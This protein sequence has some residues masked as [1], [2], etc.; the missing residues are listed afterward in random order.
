MRAA[1]PASEGQGLRG[2]ESGHEPGGGRG[3]TAETRYVDVVTHPGTQ[4]LRVLDRRNEWGSILAVAC[5]L[6]DHR[7]PRRKEALGSTRNIL[8]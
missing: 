6:R 7:W 4:L 5:H 1:W 8:R 3:V 2:D